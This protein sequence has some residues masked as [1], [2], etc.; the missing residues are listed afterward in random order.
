ME[1]KSFFVF[2]YPM[3]IYPEIVY[4][5]TIKEKEGPNKKLADRYDECI[6][7]YKKSDDDIKK[8]FFEMNAIKHNMVN[9]FFYE[10]LPYNA[11][12]NPLLYFTSLEINIHKTKPIFEILGKIQN[13]SK[14]KLIRTNIVGEEIYQMIKNLSYCK[15]MEK[16]QKLHLQ[17]LYYLY[18]YLEIGGY[19]FTTLYPCSDKQVEYFYLLSLLFKKIIFV[20]ELW[21]LCIGYLG[22]SRISKKQL[23]KIINEKYFSILPKPNMKEFVQ[24][25]NRQL[26][27]ECNFYNYLLKKQNRQLYIFMYKNM[28]NYLMEINPDNIKIMKIQDEMDKIKGIKINVIQDYEKEKKRS[29]LYLQKFIKTNLK[30]AQFT[31]SILEIGMGLGV[32]TKYLKEAL[33]SFKSDSKLYVIDPNQKTIWK[34]MGVEYVKKKKDMMMMNESLITALPKIVN[35]SVS[36]DIILIHQY[37]KFDIMMYVLLFSKILL[38]TNGYLIF[39]KS[40]YTVLEKIINFMDGNYLFFKKIEDKNGFI[41]YQKIME[42]NRLEEKNVYLF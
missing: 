14:Y 39:V 6:Q 10:L 13:E 4:K 22:E 29:L 25:I 37:D 38:R 3:N 5:K 21:V 11:E 15:R 27:K 19:Y 2:S 23:E 36:F 16:I 31:K 30:D 1:N 20:G 18:E 34:D 41:I 7:K 32:Y 26:S 40:V 33:E 35:T 24:Y 28:L 42:D 12:E 17:Y 8:I 9:N